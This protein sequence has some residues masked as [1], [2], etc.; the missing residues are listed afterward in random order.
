MA[1]QLVGVVFDPHRWRFGGAQGFDA[2][3][4]GRR[5]VVN[6]DR[7]GYLEEPDQLEPVQALGAGLVAVDLRQPAVDGRV[8]GDDPVDVGEAEESMYAVHHRHDCGVHQAAFAETTD[9]ELHVGAGCRSGGRARCPRTRRTTPAAGRRTRRG[10]ARSSEPS[11]TPPQAA[12]STS[13]PARTAT[14]WK[15]WT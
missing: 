10:C 2:Q 7:L 14:G 1:A 15:D 6:R 13:S 11:R 12:R 3:Q 4:V 5:A 8:R 9:V